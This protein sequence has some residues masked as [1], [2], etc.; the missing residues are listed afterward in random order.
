MITNFITRATCMGRDHTAFQLPPVNCVLFIFYLFFYLFINYI[1]I[2]IHLP[3]WNMGNLGDRWMSPMESGLFTTV[4]QPFPQHCGVSTHSHWHSLLPLSRNLWKQTLQQQ[5]VGW[6]FVTLGVSHITE[7]YLWL[8]VTF[9]RFLIIFI[10]LFLG[11]SFFENTGFSFLCKTNIW[12]LYRLICHWLLVPMQ[13][14]I[15]NAII[16]VWTLCK[17]IC[18]TQSYH[19]VSKVIF[20]KLIFVRIT[21]NYYHDFVIL[22]VLTVSCWK[23][24][25]SLF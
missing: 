21:D 12:F 15:I 6:D 5:K 17:F 18:C 23:G 20:S 3:L 25:H 11:R 10:F 16:I 4:L 2:I 24:N 14:I 9:L 1:I 13:F 19:I 8:P 22:S 7:F